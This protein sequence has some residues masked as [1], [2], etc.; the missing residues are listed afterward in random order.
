MSNIANVLIINGHNQVRLYTHW[1]RYQLPGQLRAAL[2]RGKNRWAD[3]PYLARIIFC[4][5]IQHD[6]LGE[7]GYG[8]YGS[9]DYDEW[10]ITVDCADQ[11]VTFPNRP[12]ISIADF[13]ASNI[14]W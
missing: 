9:S 13:A 11:T 1:E 7:L 10:T 6:V 5:M 3:A 8:I 14:D 2:L 12:P 4:E